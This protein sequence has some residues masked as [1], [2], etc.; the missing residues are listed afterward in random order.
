MAMTSHPRTPGMPVD[1]ARTASLALSTILVLALLPLVIELAGAALGGDIAGI[2]FY[3]LF[4]L[5]PLNLGVVGAV[6][7]I[8]R[9]ENVIGWLL[10]VA[11]VLTG[12]TFAGGEYE[13]SAIAAGAVDWPLLVPAA[14]IARSW[15]IPAIGILVVFLPLLYPTGRLLGRRWRWVAIAGVFGVAAGAIGPMVAPGPMADPRGPLN[16]L[17][18][19]EPLLTWIETAAT[20]STAIAPPVFVLALSSLLLRFRRSRGA[21][22][23]QIK[24]FLFVA[25]VAT[26]MFVVSILDTG[27]ISDVA[28]AL[29]LLTM[30]FLP[31]A[32]GLAILRYRLYDIDRVVS[33]AVGYTLVTATLA[34][35]FAAAVIVTQTVLAPVT[36]SST[37]AVAASTLVVAALFQPVRRAIQGRVDRRFDRSRVSAEHLV[38]TFGE[39]L[40][41]VTDLSTIHETLVTTARTTWSPTAVDVWVRPPR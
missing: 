19:P 6:L 1:R 30:I 32:I 21:E 35:T 41:D 34:V 27:P 20:L 31:L 5:L 9:P 28:W 38:S 23:Q 10:L 8:R 18:P 33:R 15:F 12:L 11:G 16:P 7:T 24:W 36:Q 39:T 14:W 29:G 40:R 22:R 17:V 13:R 26:A 37:L 2:P 4:L 25:S 3:L